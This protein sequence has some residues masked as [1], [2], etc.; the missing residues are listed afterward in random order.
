M[1]EEEKYFTLQVNEIQL[2]F[3]PQKQ[4]ETQIV[5]TG[6]FN[7]DLNNRRQNQVSGEVQLNSALKFLTP[8]ILFLL[9]LS[10]GHFSC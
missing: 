1:E 5:F 4:K 3:F 10:Q 2:F 9:L 6:S 8:F 7:S